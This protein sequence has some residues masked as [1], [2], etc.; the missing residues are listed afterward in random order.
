MRNHRSLPVLLHR[1]FPL[2]L[3]QQTIP[4]CRKA[5]G[6][7]CKFPGASSGHTVPLR[8]WISSQEHRQDAFLCVQLSLVCHAVLHPDTTLN[9]ALRHPPLEL[10]LS[11]LYDTTSHWCFQPPRGVLPQCWQICQIHWFPARVSWC[12]MRSSRKISLC[13]AEGVVLA[14][15]WN[16][17]VTWSAGHKTRGWRWTDASN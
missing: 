4:E 5:L 8:V 3:G 10:M 9:S 17:A 11:H 7:S 16:Y 13:G 12:G 14:W 2:L 1:S 6:F 15:C